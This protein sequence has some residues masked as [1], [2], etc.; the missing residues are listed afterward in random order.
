[1]DVINALPLQVDVNANLQ[2]DAMYLAEVFLQ[3]CAVLL[4]QRLTHYVSSSWIAGSCITL[5]AL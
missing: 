2:F 4:P 1:M 5:P 3:A